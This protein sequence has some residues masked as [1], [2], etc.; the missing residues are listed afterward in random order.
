MTQAV[1]RKAHCSQSQQQALPSE[2]QH[3]DA[4]ASVGLHPGCEVHETDLQFEWH[5]E[6]LSLPDRA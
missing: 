1:E 4:R 6:R 5:L 3:D 2:R